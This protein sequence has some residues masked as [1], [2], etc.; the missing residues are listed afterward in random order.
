MPDLF[1]KGNI[2]TLNPYI[3]ADLTFRHNVYN[4]RRMP[5]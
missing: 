1:S 5:I 4:A 3:G 2:S